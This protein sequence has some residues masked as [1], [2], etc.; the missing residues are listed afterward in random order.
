M[1]IDARRRAELEARIARARAC[2]AYAEACAAL[3][4]KQAPVLREIARVKGIGKRRA[5]KLNNGAEF[6]EGTAAEHAETARASSAEALEA[7]LAMR[8]ELDEPTCE[9]KS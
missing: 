9:V 2:L 7:L 1:N 3:F 6:I 8:A 4:A 5:A